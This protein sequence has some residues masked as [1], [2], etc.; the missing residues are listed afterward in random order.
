MLRK[1]ASLRSTN[2][3]IRVCYVFLPLCLLHL[4]AC[5]PRRPER[6]INC[7]Y[8]RSNRW[9]GGIRMR[10]W[11]VRDSGQ[12]ERCHLSC[13]FLRCNVTRD[14]GEEEVRLLFVSGGTEVASIC[15]ECVS[16]VP[17]FSL[18]PLLPLLLPFH[19]LFTVSAISFNT[20]PPLAKKD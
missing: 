10:G 8:C 14:L 2:T 5:Q 13:L 1:V 16:L 19:Q 18:L 17:S 7:F 20:L 11:R 15:C 6:S 9:R 3:S 12:K 4:P